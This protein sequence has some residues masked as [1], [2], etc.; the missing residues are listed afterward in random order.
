MGEENH[1]LCCLFSKFSIISAE[2]IPVL[3]GSLV[4]RSL[5]NIY[6]SNKVKL[7][8]KRKICDPYFGQMK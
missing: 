8:E 7:S 3:S 5:M 4:G 2:I 6:F 1:N